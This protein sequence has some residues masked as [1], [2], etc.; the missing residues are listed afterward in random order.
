MTLH[1]TNT[2]LNEPTGDV[3]YLCLESSQ[4]VGRHEDGHTVTDRIRLAD[5]QL[6]VI[7]TKL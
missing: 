3:G 7:V 5:C 4:D 6:M 1:L 2:E